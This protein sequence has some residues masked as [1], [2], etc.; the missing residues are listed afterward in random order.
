[1]KEVFIAALQ[2]MAGWL[3]TEMHFMLS[4]NRQQREDEDDDAIFEPVRAWVNR[5]SDLT[6]RGCFL[7][8]CAKAAVVKLLLSA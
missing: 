7:E 3:S 6:G 8:D 1:M 4:P 5:V 2:P